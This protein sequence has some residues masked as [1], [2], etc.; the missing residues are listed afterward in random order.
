MKNE[1]SILFTIKS[2]IKSHQ[3]MKNYNTLYESSVF[4]EN[5]QRKAQ[6]KKI[7]INIFMVFVMLSILGMFIGSYF[8]YEHYHSKSI[9]KPTPKSPPSNKT[10]TQIDHSASII[11]ETYCPYNGL[12]GL[13]KQCIPSSNI[14]NNHIPPL[15]VLIGVGWDPIQGQIKL[16]FLQMS[17]TQNK[18]YTSKTGKQY[19]IP[20]EVSL[21]E[22]NISHQNRITNIYKTIDQYLNNIDP[23]RTTI[24]SGT[25][26]LPVNDIPYFLHFFDNGQSIISSTTEY[27]S[28]FN[29]D[30]TDTQIIIPSVQQAINSLPKVY[31]S[32][33]YN[34]FIEYWGTSIVLSGVAGGLGQQTV[35]M[36]QCF[37]GIDF[38]S[39]SELYMLK[40]LYA[41]EYSHV[42]LAAGF[43]QYSKASI[44]DMYG[45]N[46]QY[47]DPKDWQ[48]RVNSFDDNPV[49][50]QVI[51]KP[52][53]EYITDP[54]IKANM[55]KAID[56]Y[57]TNGINEINKYKEDYY[58]NIYGPKKYDYVAF[59]RGNYYYGTLGT[60]NINQSQLSGFFPNW[61]PID[62]S[63]FY[64]NTNG[65]RTFTNYC[66]RDGNGNIRSNIDYAG[67][68]V[69]Y[70]D[71]KVKYSILQYPESVWYGCSVNHIQV[72]YHVDLI[73]GEHEYFDI[74]NV[75]CQNCIPTNDLN[76][77]CICPSF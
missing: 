37:G 30:L 55:I 44:I 56:E 69:R 73:T 43:E 31:D 54:I 25:L 2:L 67:L 3:D 61:T 66:S 13:S 77:L 58:N 74:Y 23:N 36:K 51:V 42:N 63:W 19:H 15:S 68:N 48:T 38:S 7:C 41:K 14:K 17:Y 75:C 72:S 40:Q 39:Q 4:D 12:S 49:L 21:K 1:P 32:Y 26:G 70:N 28:N 64:D 20:D 10:S 59:L 50:T 8:A 16:P 57:Y 11:K 76:N 46:P 33:L 29:L 6:R 35:M 71:D 53:T 60:L 9:N 62:P 27:R 18:Y 24:Y 47:F 34:L 45:G 22:N 5:H 52:I 65:E